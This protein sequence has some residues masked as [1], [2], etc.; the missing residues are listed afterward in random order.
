MFSEKTIVKL[1]GA[2]ICRVTKLKQSFPFKEYPF[3][4]ITCADNTL[5][6][7]QLDK[8]KNTVGEH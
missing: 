5:S 7:R 3:T 8:V 6:T 4:K 1:L 2:T